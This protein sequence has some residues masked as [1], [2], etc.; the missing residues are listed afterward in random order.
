MDVNLIP[1]GGTRRSLPL[2]LASA[3]LLTSVS[4]FAFVIYVHH[5]GNSDQIS[6][7]EGAGTELLNYQW[8]DFSDLQTTVTKLVKDVSALQAKVASD[9]TNTANTISAVEANM[10]KQIA[11]VEANTS[12]VQIEIDALR[13]GLPSWTLVMKLTGATTFG[14]SSSYWTNSATLNPLSP[15]D[16]PADAKYDAFN[17]QGVKHL[18]MCIG[19]PKNNCLS[20]TL[21]KTYG[22]CKEL[23][24]AGY[25][26]SSINTSQWMTA[27]G[28]TSGAYQNCPANK[29][30]FNS[31]CPDG[32]Y[33]RWGYCNNCANQNCNS[34]PY[35][36]DGTVGIGLIG[37]TTGAQGAG[38]TGYFASGAGTCSASGGKTSRNIWLW[39]RS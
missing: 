18:K 37:Q 38:W 17:N 7:P 19:H 8:Y 21:A 4:T 16:T 29:P 27:F 22:S 35:D 23:F 13:N 31:F 28:V 9:E 12:Q 36:A 20:T 11:A 1:S 26:E 25:I 3:A 32:N 10:S 24:A 15:L 30:G 39:V 33:A 5:Q 6:I 34:Y 2:L 14:Y